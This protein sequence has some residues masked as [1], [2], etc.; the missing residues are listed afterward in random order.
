MHF[1]KSIRSWAV[2]QCSELIRVSLLR[3]RSSLLRIELASLKHWSSRQTIAQS[4]EN[5]YSVF[6]SLS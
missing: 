4:H 5:Q 2:I 3:S 6:R 1:P